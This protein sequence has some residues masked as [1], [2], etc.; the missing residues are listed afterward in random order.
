MNGESDSLSERLL[1]HLW[2]QERLSGN[3]LDGY[4]R[5]LAKIGSRLQAAG[6]H[7]LDADAEDL[8]CAVYAPHEQNRSQAR[9]LSA[10][11]RLYGWLADTGQRA[12]NPTEHLK[13]PKLP[14]SLPPIVSETQISRL[15]DAPDC[16]TPLGLRDKAL[17]EL[18]YATGLRV[19]EAVRLRPSEIDLQSGVVNTLGKGGKQR[20]VPLGEEAVYWLERYLV[21]ARA[22]ILKGN[23]CDF[24]LVGQK[25]TGITRQ[26]AWQIVEKYAAQAGIHRLSPHSLRHAFATHLVNHGADL[27]VVQMLLGHADLSTTQI[28]TYVA[29]ERL[30]HIVQTHHPRAASV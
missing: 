20:L 8:A 3:T 9:A 1:D 5:D 14:K 26:L 7:W 4:R 13:A 19:S 21:Q 24:L 15:L 17:L 27:R 11:R 2:L 30:K 12:D 6:K 22:A 25:K 23:R 29:N 18:L 10:C 16:E 28:Y